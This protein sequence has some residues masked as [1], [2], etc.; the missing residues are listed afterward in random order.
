MNVKN[1]QRRRDS[2]PRPSRPDSPPINKARA[3]THC[4]A[5]NK[6]AKYD[7]TFHK[8]RYLFLF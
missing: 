5:F 7:W 1:I 4:N 6:T 3:P 2:N 8:F